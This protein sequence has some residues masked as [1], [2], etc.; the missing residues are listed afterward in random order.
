V[1]LYVRAGELVCA[2]A[3]KRTGVSWHAQPLTEPDPIKEALAIR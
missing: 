1:S 3:P 2:A